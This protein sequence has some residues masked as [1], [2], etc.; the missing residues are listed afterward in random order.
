MLQRQTSLTGGEQR[1]NGGLVK[2]RFPTSQSIGQ[3]LVFVGESI[4]E[5]F[6]LTRQPTSLQVIELSPVRPMSPISV[7]LPQPLPQAWA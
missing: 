5:G 7:N 1:V 2:K 6:G 4:Y 3:F